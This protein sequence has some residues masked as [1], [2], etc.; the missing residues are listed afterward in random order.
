MQNRPRTILA[1]DH[2]MLVE[3]FAK[4]LEDH[5][6]IVAT[7]ENGRDLIEVATRLKPEVIILD[8]SMPLLNGLGACEKLLKLSPIPKLI[9]LTVNED[10]EIV[11][12][13][14]RLGASGYLLKSSAASELLEALNQVMMGRSYITPLVTNSMLDTVLTKSQELP[15]HKKISPRQA[16]VLQL[17][18][19]GFSMKEAARMLDLSPRTVA[20]HKYRIM[21]EQH[22]ATNADLIQFAIRKGLISS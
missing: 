4:I 17:L 7:A 6:D 1:D 22:L 9:F 5:V 20:F 21:E 19:E 2:H 8:I 16:E 11:A 12:E 10:P 18:A 14:F 15:S 13:A 3:A